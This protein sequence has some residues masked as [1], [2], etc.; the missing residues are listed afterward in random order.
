MVGE[1]LD[2]EFKRL[3]EIWLDQ[4]F[5]PFVE[6]L[7]MD[8]RVEQATKFENKYD[9]YLGYVTGMFEGQHLQLFKQQ[10]NRDISEHERFEL[11]EIYE[12]KSKEI[13]EILMR[14][15]QSS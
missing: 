10:F 14:K 4:V 9:F 8:K 1:T 11:E 6:N 2:P 13:R 5:I 12:L 7:S 3:T 15:C